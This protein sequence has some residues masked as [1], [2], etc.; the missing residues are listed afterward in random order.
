MKKY[1]LHLTNH[2]NS[3]E[4]LK[5]RV[6]MLYSKQYSQT[7]LFKFMLV[8]PVLL[9]ATLLLAFVYPYYTALEVLPAPQTAQLSLKTTPV[10]TIKKTKV[11]SKPPPQKLALPKLTVAEMPAKVDSPQVPK[12][13]LTKRQ[14]E[15]LSSSA[16]FFHKNAEPINEAT[17][18]YLNE[19]V[20]LLKEHPQIKLLVAGH[21]ANWGDKEERYQGLSLRRAQVVKQYLSENGI[22]EKRLTIKGYGST[23]PAAKNDTEFGKIKNNRV[24]FS[25]LTKK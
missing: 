10:Q 11:L 12:Y 15:V 16:Y 13:N 3:I 1:P 19:V 2:F 23:K 14:Q 7:Q 6:K 17:M 24:T 8:V 18:N 20:T 4:S 22:D 21:T 9:G 5:A 25:I